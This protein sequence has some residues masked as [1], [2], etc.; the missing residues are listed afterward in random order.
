MFSQMD[1]FL[2]D[3][4]AVLGLWLGITIV[5]VGE[6]LELLLDIAIYLLIQMIN[7]SKLSK[8]RR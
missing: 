4:S 5:T 3:V 8:K 7:L 6:F 1:E 2:T